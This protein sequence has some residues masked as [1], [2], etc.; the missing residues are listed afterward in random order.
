[1]VRVP[2]SAG[3]YCLMLLSGGEDLRLYSDTPSH[4]AMDLDVEVDIFYSMLTPKRFSL[5][6][7]DPPLTETGFR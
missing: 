4:F 7:F 5:R 6:S 3:C 1:M 2:S